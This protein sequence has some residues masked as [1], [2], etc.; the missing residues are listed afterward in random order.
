MDLIVDNWHGRRDDGTVVHEPALIDIR[1]AI[2]ALD[3][4]SRTVISLSRSEECYLLVAGQYNGGYLV[5]GTLT[6]RD[7]YS[8]KQPSED[9]RK[10][11]CCIGG[12]DGEYPVDLFVPLDVAWQAVEYFYRSHGLLPSLDWY[13]QN[14]RGARLDVST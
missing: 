14:G 3:G 1:R 10:I 5:N 6:G 8:L 7:F 11:V 2:T 4:T 13:S 12:Q 9:R